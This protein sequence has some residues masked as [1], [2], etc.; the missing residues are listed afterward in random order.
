MYLFSYLP[1]R[2]KIDFTHKNTPHHRKDLA[3]RSFHQS[4]HHHHH[5]HLQ[6]T[7]FLASLM[8]YVYICDAKSGGFLFYKI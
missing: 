1:Q 4:P 2:Y 6:I 7:Q 8:N 5:F 3:E